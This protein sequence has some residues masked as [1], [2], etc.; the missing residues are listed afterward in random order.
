[1]IDDN[2]YLPAQVSKKEWETAKCDKYDYMIAVFCGG[3]AGLIDAFFV[4]DPLTSILG[5]SVDK[6]ADGFVKKAARFFLSHDNRTTGKSRKMPQTLEQCISYLEQAFPVNYD[7]RYAKDLI[8]EEDTLSG[9]RPLN[10]HLLSLAHSPDPIGLIFSIIDQFMGYASF[11][12][13]GKIIHVVPKRTSGAIPYMQGTDLPSMLFCGFVNWIGHLISDLVGSSSTRKDG[14]TGRGAGHPIPF[15]ELF[16]FC[17]FG[18]IDGKTLSETMIKVFEEGF[19]FRFGL[20]MAI[21]VVMEELMIKVIWMIRQKFIRKK[22]WKESIPTSVHA[23]LRVMLVVG[24]GTLCAIDGIDAA[25][26]GLVEGGNVVS[27]I[28]HLN[29]VGWAR[30]AMLILK[31]LAI[32][33]GPVINQVLDKFIQS[34]LGILTPAEQGRIQELQRRLGE[35]DEYLWALFCE[36]VKQVEHEYKELYIEIHETFSEDTTNAYR[37][38]HSVKLAEVS[39]VSEDKIIR[40]KKQLDDLFL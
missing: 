4:G 27:F 16:L 29:L 36:F 15:Y 9:M 11:V 18:N 40:N 25:A 21:P 5:K 32:R 17:D 34:I 2:A 10:H 33:M 3:T 24:N 37:A 30:L 7:A 19:D 6:A 20:T 8:V 38:E 14:K 39:G 23:D 13:K 31:E 1:M 26:H 28:C 12:D 35:Y 22:T